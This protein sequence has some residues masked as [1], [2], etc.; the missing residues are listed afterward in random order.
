MRGGDVAEIHL[1]DEGL[2][3]DRRRDLAGP[4]Q[5]RHQL[6]DALV[7]RLEEMLGKQEVGDAVERVVVDQDR[8]QQRLLGLDV[9]RLDA[10]FGLAVVEA[11][12][13]GG[14]GGHGH[15]DGLST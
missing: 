13:E 5:A 15:P 3:R 1:A 4:D 12:D 2:Q 7:D 14:G 9:V 8:A 10:V 6:E 11:G